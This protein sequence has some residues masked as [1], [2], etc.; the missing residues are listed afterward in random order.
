VR[1]PEHPNTLDARNRLA[2]AIAAQGR[3]SEAETEYRNVL[4]LREKVLGVEHPDTLETCCNLATCLRAEGK[5][6]EAKAF[7]QRA[8]E[9]AQKVLGADHPDTKKY[10]QLWQE[11]SAKAS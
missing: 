3:Y 9:E 7:A 5:T 11:L 8:A 6:Q 2:D 1:G 10:E 4:T